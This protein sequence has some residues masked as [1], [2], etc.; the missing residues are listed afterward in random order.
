MD[1]HCTP[2]NLREQVPSLPVFSEASQFH[3][4]LDF[5][6][7][8]PHNPLPGIPNEREPARYARV[9]LSSPVYGFVLPA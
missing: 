8:P 9:K 1:T 5:C 7:K 2:M 3:D 4:F 6:T